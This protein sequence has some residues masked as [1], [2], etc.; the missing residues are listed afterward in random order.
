MSGKIIK[1]IVSLLCLYAL[2]A[3]AL[4]GTYKWVDE[5]G[6]VVY[7]QHPPPAGK[8]EALSVKP[9]P[10][11][12]QESNSA[13]DQNRKFLDDAENQRKSDSKLKVENQKNQETRKKNCETAKKQ[14]EFY[15]VYRRR[16]GKDGEYVRITEKEREAKQQEARQGIKDFCD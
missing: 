10:R 5:E 7:S 11:N 14:L 1:N 3:T 16:K 12:R 8:Y 9:A 2:T 15:T 6:N 13:P 4:A